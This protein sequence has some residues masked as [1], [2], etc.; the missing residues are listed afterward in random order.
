M[1]TVCDFCCADMDRFQ[2]SNDGVPEVMPGISQAHPRTGSF[3]QT[4]RESVLKFSD[5]ATNGR[6]RSSK[7]TSRKG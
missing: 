5:M 2:S 7:L 4:Y 6:L 3:K 1:R